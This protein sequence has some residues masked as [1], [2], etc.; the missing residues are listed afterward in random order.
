MTILTN[1]TTD[2]IPID[3]LTAAD[4]K[5][6]PGGLTALIIII[7]VLILIVVNQIRV[8]RKTGWLPH[9]LRWYIFGGLTVLVLAFLP[10]LNLRIHHYVLA[11][12]LI[13]GTAFPTRLSAIYQGFL[14]GMFLN[15]A[16]AWGFDSI[17]QTAAQVR[18]TLAAS[19]HEVLMLYISS[20]AP[21]RR[22][23]G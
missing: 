12:A 15:G 10:T 11:M 8:I 16:A 1:L 5:A 20:S 19:S 17:L 13:P 22:R 2:K 3:R 4:I 14:L 23:V 18:L 9:Y 6:Q 21:A 7:I